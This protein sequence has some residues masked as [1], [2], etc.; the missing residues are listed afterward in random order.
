[1]CSNFRMILWFTPIYHHLGWRKLQHTVLILSSLYVIIVFASPAE[2]TF[3]F[4]LSPEPLFN[5]HGRMWLF[6]CTEN[7]LKLICDEINDRQNRIVHKRRREDLG[8]SYSIL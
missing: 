4:K 5:L 8:I 6:A 7:E 1:M 2:V 3:L